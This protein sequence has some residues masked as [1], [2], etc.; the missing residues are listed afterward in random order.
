MNLYKEASW[1][2][3]SNGKEGSL[4]T[5]IFNASKSKKIKSDPKH[6]YALVSST[7]K[8]KTFI[9][10]IMKKSRLLEEERALKEPMA[11]LLVHDLLFSKSGRIQMGKNPLK[12]SVLR[13]K[14]RLTAE[15]TKLKLKHKVK[16][17]EEIIDEDDTPVR[18]FRVNTLLSDADAVLEQFDL[19]EVN[20]VEKIKPGSIF[21]D[22][23]IPNL[24]GVSPKERITQSLPY[25]RGEIIIQDRA[26]CF[27]AFI[28]N[29][30][31]GDVVIDACAAPGNK[32]THLA[33]HVGFKGRID[34]FE[35]DGRR[36]NILKTMVKKAGADPIVTVN[37]GDFT[38]SNPDDFPQVTGLVV[39][40]S[41]SGSGIFGRAHEEENPEDSYSDE[42]LQKLSSFQFS[43]VKH[44]LSF[45]NATR[46]VYSTCSIHAQE[47]ERVVIDLI[48]DPQVKR[49]GWR[50]AN[51][52]RVIPMWPRRGLVEEFEGY[53]NP[54]QLAGGCVR[55]LPKVDGGIGFFAVLFERD[56]SLNEKEGFRNQNSD[57]SEDVNSSLQNRERDIEASE[58]EDWNGFD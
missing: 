27:P 9:L 40:P 2:L 53:P 34:A 49:S 1:F 48:N 7:L 55:A 29:P 38:Q 10:V 6:I 16:S 31:E 47:N 17:L 15:L 46:V 19:T 44:A 57:D 25:E 3:T 30:K 28:M 20:S 33:A 4:Q 14:T 12:D 22:K 52:S 8:Y 50:V 39:D 58:Y 45:P 35:R 56:P 24:F 51:R 36:S 26:S 11:L 23:Y 41:C 32:T 54:E 5:R 18:W 43:I 13:H 37:V 21:K 42:R